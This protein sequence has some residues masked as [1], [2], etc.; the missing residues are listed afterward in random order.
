VSRAAAFHPN[1]AAALGTPACG[2]GDAFSS[3][4]LC[5]CG[6]ISD[7]CASSKHRLERRDRR[8]V[9]GATSEKSTRASRVPWAVWNWS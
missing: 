5:L 4:A 1:A 7:T 8:R 3:V 2:G 9:P 6:R